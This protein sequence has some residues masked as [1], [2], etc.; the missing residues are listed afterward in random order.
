MPFGPQPIAKFAIRHS[1][2]E[3]FG[4]PLCLTGE[5]N[6][7][8]IISYCGES[9]AVCHACQVAYTV[10]PDDTKV[11]KTLDVTLIPHPSAGG[12]VIPHPLSDQRK[13]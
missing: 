1:D 4:C 5:K 6:V 9:L 11:I 13:E 2:Y 8:V 7:T 3:E 10:I 12:N